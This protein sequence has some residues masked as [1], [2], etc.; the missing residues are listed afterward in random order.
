MRCRRSSCE[1][2]RAVHG[3][4]VTNITGQRPGVAT[5][6]WSESTESSDDRGPPLRRPSSRVRDRPSKRSAGS[7]AGSEG[8]E[9]GR[10][11]QNSSPTPAPNHRFR[12]IASQRSW[13]V[14]MTTSSSFGRWISKRSSTSVTSSKRLRESRAR[15]LRLVCGENSAFSRP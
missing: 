12:S 9:P 1:T 7:E 10:R 11:Q 13:I 8:T 5:I 2:W 6:N 15:P 3:S 4:G 14:T